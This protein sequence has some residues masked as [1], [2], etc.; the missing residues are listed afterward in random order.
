MVE[1]LPKARWLAVLLVVSAST[2]CAAQMVSSAP[3]FA[4]PRVTAAAGASPEHRSAEGRPCL[5][6][7][8][9]GNPIT[10]GSVQRTATHRRTVGVP[11]GFLV[12][13][14]IVIL[15]VGGA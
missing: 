11:A 5:P 15:L 3:C 12:A 9:A 7:A 4:A 8:T 13:M 2:G 6:G 1:T 10:I 14:I